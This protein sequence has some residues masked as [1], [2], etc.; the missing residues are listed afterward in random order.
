MTFSILAGA[1]AA[2]L[3]QSSTPVQ[4]PPVFAPRPCIDARLAATARCGLVTVPENR[5]ISGGRRIDLNI[6]ILPAESTDGDLPPLFDIDGGPGLP[7]TK[8]TEF[9]L[10][11]GGAHRARRDIVL[12][13]QR[14][15]GASN[16][17]ACPELSSPETA[18]A[19]MYPRDAVIRC[20]VELELIADLTQYGTSAAIADLDDVRS[21]LGH[22]RIDI[23]A[24]SY[25]TT[26]ALR[27]LATYPDR[28]RAAVLMG[29][30]PADAMPPQ[31]HATAGE[32]GLGLVFEDCL[33]DSACRSA[34]PDPAGDLE[35][36]V[37]RLELPSAPVSV[38]VFMERLR[39]LMYSP[40]GARRLPSIIHHAAEGDMTPFFEATRSRGP[41]L[42]AEGMY[43]STTCVESI[44]FI[45]YERAAAAANDTRFGDYRLRRQ[46]EACENWPRGTVADRHFAPVET[47]AAVLLIS[48]RFDP[49]TPPE[50]AEALVG[51]MPRSRHLVLARGGHIVDGLSNLECLDSIIQSFFDT[52]DPAALD[53]ACLAEM[54]PPPFVV[55]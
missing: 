37:A 48:G 55:E 22:E 7:G 45:D 32:R 16:A 1:I 29:V 49:V 25:G 36:S 50:W 21:A 28:V 9:Y 6:V 44:G 42:L 24:L 14:G 33:A 11:Y 12:V 4:P 52:A 3:A 47:D 18:Y 19:E 53:I 2:M 54:Q 38:A 23:V 34:F 27:Y 43:L 30:V 5:A 31:Y 51:G 41:S 40:D 39:S 10:T 26:V 46:R 20:R 17:L 15:T 8:N 35:R 13:D